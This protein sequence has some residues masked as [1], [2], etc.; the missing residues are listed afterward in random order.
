MFLV[1][2]VLVITLFG[3]CTKFNKYTLPTSEISEALGRDHVQNLYPSFI[4]LHTMIFIGFGFLMTFLKTGA[5]SSLLFTLII[6]FWA[7]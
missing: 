3:L 2:Q 4:Q 7:F 1:G 5:W 6:G